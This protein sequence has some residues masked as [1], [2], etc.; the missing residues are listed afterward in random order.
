MPDE[1][2]CIF[3]RK[4]QVAYLDFHTVSQFIRN[5]Q[6][7]LSI[8]IQLQGSQK[9]L[10]L[11]STRL[12]ANA[13]V[14]FTNTQLAWRNSQMLVNHFRVDV[15]ERQCECTISSA[16]DSCTDASRRRL[17]CH[18]RP[19]PPLRHGADDTDLTRLTV[20]RHAARQPLRLSRHPVVR[21]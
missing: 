15:V 2:N 11:F 6:R 21:P 8:T 20:S 13:L 12:R 5:R 4:S 10:E 9:R 18:E 7:D 3:R 1:P 17:L 19:Q 14:D 16:F